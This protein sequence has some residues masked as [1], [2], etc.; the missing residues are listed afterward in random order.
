M[1][2]LF[3]ALSPAGARSRLSLLIFHRVQ[4]QVDPLFPE[5]L[6]AARFDVLCGWLRR[7]FQ[8]LPLDLAVRQ[9]QQGTLPG[10]ALA[11]TFDDGYADNHDVALPILRR[12]GLPATFFI[13]TGFLDGGEMWNDTLIEAVRGTALSEVVLPPWL[14]QPAPCATV[15][16]KRRL[17]DTL[18][19]R[20]KYLPPPQRLAAVREIA[21][22]LAAPAHAP[23]MMTSGQV[24]ALRDAGMQIGAHTVNH[25]ILARL[26]ADEARA[27]MATSRDT[28]QALLAQPVELFAY[29]NGRPD[30]DYTDTTVRLARELGFSAAVTTAWGAARRGSDLFQLPRFTPWDRGRVA[31]AARLARNLGRPG[32]LAAASRMA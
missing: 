24:V 21:E 1:R 7:W 16:D 25:P 29:P 11:I 14:P 10:R 32:A 8:V 19:P 26:A 23:L 22:A 15:A 6:D 31:F 30:E 4:P 12:H 27:E 17:I 5:E 13:A 28:L 20:L 9:L 18:L 2:L 3:D